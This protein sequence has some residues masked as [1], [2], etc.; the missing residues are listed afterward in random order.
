MDEFKG[1]NV[2][3]VSVKKTLY[4][5]WKY[6]LSPNALVNRIEE[7]ERRSES[8]KIKRINDEIRERN[9]EKFG[10]FSSFCREPYLKEPTEEYWKGFRQGVLRT[11]D[12]SK[13]F[14]VSDALQKEELDEFIKFITDKGIQI[15]STSTGAILVTKGAAIKEIE[16]C[17][18]KYN[19]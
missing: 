18:L 9:I 5:D 11:I 7:D 19:Y 1:P 15:V 17:Q 3:V 2:E 14:Y 4:K 12:W 13:T 10:I 8:S 16:Y 6:V